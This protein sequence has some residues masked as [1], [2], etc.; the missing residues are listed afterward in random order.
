MHQKSL[1]PIFFVDNKKSV[2]R[3]AIRNTERVEMGSS[4]VNASVLLQVV[5]LIFLLEKTVT[6]AET[7]IDGQDIS[8]VVPTRATTRPGQHSPPL[9]HNGGG[10]TAVK[11]DNRVGSTNTPTN[12]SLTSTNNSINNSSRASNDKNSSK[13]VYQVQSYL[14]FTFAGIFLATL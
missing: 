10:D 6:G 4:L 13:S 14:F 8:T 5:F 7:T 3:A 2:V 12:S 11:I 1:F 9:V